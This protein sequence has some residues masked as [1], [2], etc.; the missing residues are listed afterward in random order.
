MTAPAAKTTAELALEYG[1]KPDE[2]A[3]ILR[4]VLLVLRLLVCGHVHVPSVSLMLPRRPSARAGSG[5]AS[6]PS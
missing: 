3:L 5:A 4:P 1:L 6:S 2:Y